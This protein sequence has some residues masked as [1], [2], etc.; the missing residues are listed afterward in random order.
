M[1]PPDT[2]RVMTWNILYDTSP[3]GGGSGVERWPLVLEGVRQ[4]SPDLLAM[5]EVLPGRIAA[6][7]HD[8]PEYRLAASEPG[9]TDRAIAP[10]LAVAAAALVLLVLRRR[11][12]RDP[13]IVR[14]PLRRR[15]GHLIT[16]VLW[17]IVLGIPAALAYGSW[18]L[19]GYGTLN[20]QLAFAY[21]PERLR[22]VE[23]RTYWFS[24]T[25]TK[26]GT[27][28]PFS[29]EPRIAQLGVF[30]LEPGG[31]TLTV[32]NVHP[33][34]S[35]SA[36]ASIAELLRG[37]LDRRWNGAPQILLGDFNATHDRERLS[38]LRETRTTGEPP[39]R[40]AWLE[41]PERVGS[42]GTFNWAKTS[43]GTLRIDHV[44]VRGPLRT[45]SA[46]TIAVARD[47]LIA[48]DHSAVVVDLVRTDTMST[49]PPPPEP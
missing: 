4:A 17:L 20:E 15:F 1:S 42:P 48:S 11:R 43:P 37:V 13:T 14:G 22:L 7:P 27:R 5:Q 31:E 33:G 34:H 38:L 19:G 29:F 45:L 23:T 16:A 18:Y 9:G 36:D 24:P 8:L 47:K 26:P 35:P 30:T 32:V 39:F 6:L 12:H 25:P 44:L 49:P 28:D 21:R 10:L 46:E 3:V 40:D 41:A 2:L